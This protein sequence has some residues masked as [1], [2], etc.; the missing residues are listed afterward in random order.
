M[1]GIDWAGMFRPETPVLEL[2]VRGAVVYLALFVLLR[3]VRHREAGAMG[4][5]DLLVIVLLADAAQNAM[6]GGYRSITDGVILVATIV[7][8][9]LLL[10]WLGYRLPS[11]LQ[12]LVRPKAIPLIEDGRALPWNLR[13]ELITN[14]ELMAQLRLHGMDAVADVKGAYLESD[15]RISVVPRVPR[16]AASPDRA[17]P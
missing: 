17:P 11:S 8:C 12:L 10:D 6:A 14:D 15:G 1:R 2:V 16:P 7:L 4:V 9:A 13:R 5:T 3:V